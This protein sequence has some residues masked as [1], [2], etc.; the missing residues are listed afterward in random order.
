MSDH[1][2]LAEEIDNARRSIDRTLILLKTQLS[3]MRER[4]DLAVENL[5]QKGM[6]ADFSQIGS[7]HDQG[8]QLDQLCKRLEKQKM[9]LEQSLTYIRLIK[10]VQ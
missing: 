5:N 7:M 8:S 1:Q 3:T 4:L 2:V 6:D 9:F 10:M